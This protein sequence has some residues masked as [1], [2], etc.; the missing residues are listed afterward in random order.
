[1]GNSPVWPDLVLKGGLGNIPAA[2]VERIE[3]INN[4]SAKYDA[5]GMAGIINIIY[6]KEKEFGLNGSI[7]LTYGLGELTTRKESLPTHLGR[8]SLNSKYIPSLSLNYR[9]AKTNA[10]FQG[11]VIRQ[12]KS[13]K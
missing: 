1:M 3:I 12:K 11:E 6:K 4:P 7:G 8:F 2:N 9:T 5:A 10:Y 13:A